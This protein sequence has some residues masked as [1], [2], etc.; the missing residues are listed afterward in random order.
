MGAVGRGAY[1]R[2]LDTRIM[3]V[4]VGRKPCGMRTGGEGRAVA[5]TA[6]RAV[7]GGWGLDRRAGWDRSVE[8]D[9]MP[10]AAVAVGRQLGGR[11]EWSLS[12]AQNQLPMDLTPGPGSGGYIPPPHIRWESRAAVHLNS[13][14]ASSFKAPHT[15]TISAR[16]SFTM[17]DIPRGSQSS[18]PASFHARLTL[19]KINAIKCEPRPCPV[20]GSALTQSI[21]PLGDLKTVGH[22]CRKCDVHLQEHLSP[23]LHRV[24]CRIF[25]RISPRVLIP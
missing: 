10:C 22:H 17:P 11:A 19:K 8:L 13:L 21:D 6:G 12:A 25:Y 1:G 24:D 14:V 18:F 3:C 5:V 2:R 7:V 16:R 20:C 15:A 4:S 23:G 9:G